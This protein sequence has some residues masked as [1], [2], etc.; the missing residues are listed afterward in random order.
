[1]PEFIDISIPL[2]NDVV[3]DPAGYQPKISY[4]GH[5]DT[6]EQ[7][8]PFFPGLK[9]EDLPDGEAWAVEKVEL[10]THNGTHL[11]APYHFHSTMNKGERA[12]T[13]DEVPLDW[14]FRPGVKLDFSQLPDGY[15]VTANDVQQELQRIEH[16]LK[17]LEIVLVNTR[18]GSA[19]GSD[20]YVEAGCG[21][22]YEATMYLLEQGVRVT[23]TDAWSWDAPFTHTAE[24]Y[25]KDSDPSIIWEGHKA[26]MDIGYCHLEKLHNL[27]AL[28]SYGFTVSCFPV[29]IKGASAGWTR[30]VAIVDN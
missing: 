10:I 29:K 24:N 17:P 9:Q 15:V 12:I 30:A 6:F 14:C 4:M 27:E 20:D 3:S 1:M 23:G 18:A 25:A 28:P 7:I 21:M 2:E 11:D 19:Y 8:A 16:T 22:G 26:G 13:I 5:Q